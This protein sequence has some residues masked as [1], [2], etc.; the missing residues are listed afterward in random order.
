ML[1]QILQSLKYFQTETV[2]V[3]SFCVIVLAD[4]IFRKKSNVT[5]Y[6]ALISLVVATYYLGLQ[7]S[8]GIKS[9]FFNMFAVD[10]FSLFFKAII[11]TASFFVLLFSLNSKEL[12]SKTRGV[13]EYNALVIA[14]TLGMVL[15]TGATNL[16]MMYL[17]LELSSLTSYILAGYTKDAEDSSE[18]SLKYIIYGALSS[19]IMLYGIS[20]LY[21]LTG[22]VDIYGI[23]QA[24][25]FQHLN[26]AALVVAGIF[27]VVG[28]GYKISAVP[29]HFWTPDVYEGSPITIT[30]LLSV[31]SKA[32]GF[33]MLI[34]FTKV[35]FINPAIGN[36]DPGMW[37]IF[38]GIDWRFIL[39][40]LSVLSMTIGNLVAL[41]QKN[42]KRLLAYSS[43]AHAGYMLMGLVV[44]S[45]EGIAAVMIYFIVYLF[46]NLGAFYVVMLIA[47]RIGSENI[48]DYRGMG[49]RS[50]LLGVAMTIFL[51]SLTG[52]PPTAG[53]I[54]K[55]YL[56]SSLISAK[57]F[58]L[59]IVGAL[60]SV[61]SLYYYVRVLRNMFLRDPQANAQ[62]LQISFIEVFILILLVLPT[63]LLGLYFT[64][65]VEFAQASVTMFGIQ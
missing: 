33:A 8:D 57:I 56:F 65:I 25:M 24:L 48:D 62:S 6:L 37:D 18:A 22:S 41:S 19:G 36:L 60:N 39:A 26:T 64:P 63:I 16:L 4:L 28:F 27:I 13:G 21:G 15:M 44:L 45:N 20:I 34:R 32:A 10:P 31:A 61:V 58:W 3:V 2:L 14:L 40:I 23:H 53:F 50:P 42:L 59:A 35:T 29:F 30:A 9:I 54:G 49:F 7:G 55:L 47:D 11:I 46:M 43:I 1:D 51:L 17:A 12:V 38:K 5:S 52:I